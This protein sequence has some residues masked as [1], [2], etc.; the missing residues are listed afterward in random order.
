MYANKFIKREDL[1]YK[2][3]PLEVFERIDIEFSDADYF[4]EEIRKELLINL[5]KKN[6]TLM[7]L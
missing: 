1:E 6:F 5:V 2:N 4:Y 3:K 7:G